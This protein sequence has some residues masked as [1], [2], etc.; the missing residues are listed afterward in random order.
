DKAKFHLSAE[1]F[2][3]ARIGYYFSDNNRVAYKHDKHRADLEITEDG[4][5]YENETAKVNLNN[6]YEA[7][8]VEF[9]GNGQTVVNLRHAVET[10]ILA[11]AARQVLPLALRDI[12]D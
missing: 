2:A 12:E 10:A 8:K 7:R 11:Q 4:Y 9:K 1:S 5:I 3:S 6:D